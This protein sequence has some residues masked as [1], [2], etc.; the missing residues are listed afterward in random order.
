MSSPFALQEMYAS[1]FIETFGFCWILEE[2]AL[3]G[4]AFFAI[5]S[6][7]ASNYLPTCTRAALD[8]RGQRLRSMSWAAMPVTALHG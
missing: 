7:L 5:A 2:E 6:V 3:A 1:L 4:A 8:E